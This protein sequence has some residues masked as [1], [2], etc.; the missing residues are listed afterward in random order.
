MNRLLRFESHA[1][2]NFFF[3]FGHDNNFAFSST[4]QIQKRDSKYLTFWLKVADALD[5]GIQFQSLQSYKIV[6]YWYIKSIANYTFAFVG[7]IKNDVKLFEH[8]VSNH[9]TLKPISIETQTQSRIYTSFLSSYLLF[10]IPFLRIDCCTEDS[11]LFAICQLPSSRSVLLLCVYLDRKK[12][13]SLFGL[14]KKNIWL[15]LV[16]IIR[17]EKKESNKKKYTK[18][19]IRYS[20]QKALFLRNLV[21]IGCF[22]LYVSSD[23][24][25][26]LVSF[27]FPRNDDTR[28]TTWPKI[29]LWIC[30]ET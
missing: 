23:G 17:G 14:L 3:F 29:S 27:W 9:Q 5:A 18:F 1:E 6:I 12:F 28:E 15:P 22:I 11:L 4:C 24:F 20:E 21:Y 10:H 2:L 13:D 30:Y 25:W 26:V 8:F 16:M 19:E 7:A